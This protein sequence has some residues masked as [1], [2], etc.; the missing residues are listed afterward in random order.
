M[1]LSFQGRGRRVLGAVGLLGAF[2]SPAWGVGFFLP[3]QSVEATARGNAWVA[4]ADSAAAVHY[5]P[6]G[7]TQLEGPTTEFGVYTVYLGY[8]HRSDFDG[9]TYKTDRGLKAVPHLYYAQPINE[10][11]AYGL[12]LTAPF[13]LG[14]EWPSDSPFRDVAIEADLKYVRLSAVLSYELNDCLSIG[15]G[16][17]LDYADVLL[18]RG[19]DDLVSPFPDDVFEFEGDGTA[20]VWMLSLLWKPNE[21]HSFGLVYRSAADFRLDG[22]VSSK[23]VGFGLPDGTADIDFNTPATA[24]IGYNYRVN[25]RF[26]VEVNVEWVDWDSLNTLVLDGDGLGGVPVPVPFEYESSYIYELGCSYQLN[27]RARLH[28]GYVYNEVS[29]PDFFF[30]PAVP[31]SNLQSLN[32]GLSYKFDQLTLSGAYQYAWSE[33]DVDG[34]VLPSNGSYESEHHAFLVS[35]RYDF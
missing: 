10:K 3:N 34:S 21:T 4:T 32:V 17:G 18:G 23:P 31:D 27:E 35:A 30:N 7:L 15:G 12:G 29:V 16:V 1:R 25:D 26:D 6:A 28:L 5:N 20:L 22:D 24:A 14:T 19:I 9:E 2:A 8:D 33:Y 11:L 13:G